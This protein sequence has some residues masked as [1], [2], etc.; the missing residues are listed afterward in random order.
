M[1]DDTNDDYDDLSDG[2]LI[3]S[4]GI[5]LSCYTAAFVY[6]LT[7]LLG[8]TVGASTVPLNVALVTLFGLLAALI[9]VRT[10]ARWLRWRSRR[11]QRHGSRIVGDTE[12]RR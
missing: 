8:G 9:T 4:G 11:G 2:G 12:G 10:I 1:N 6:Y 5:A 7:T 3:V